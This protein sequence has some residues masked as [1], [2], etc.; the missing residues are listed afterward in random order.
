MAGHADA[1]ERRN[2]RHRV[3]DVPVEAREEPETMLAGDPRYGFVRLAAL[4]A[5]RRPPRQR[6][7]REDGAAPGFA[8][9]NPGPLGD[10][11]VEATLRQLVRRREAGDA[12]AEH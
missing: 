12:A 7:H 5:R 1:L 8:A 2:P 6:A 9:G 4:V 11:D 10:H 3:H